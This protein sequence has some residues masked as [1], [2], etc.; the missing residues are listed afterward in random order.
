MAL[1]NEWVSLGVI[2]PLISEVLSLCTHNWRFWAHLVQTLKFHSSPVQSHDAF[3]K[4]S[5]TPALQS[6]VF[7]GIPFLGGFTWGREQRYV[8]FSH[9]FS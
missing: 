2:T 3:W 1:I 5:H 9:G 6:T 4:T 7:A 8:V